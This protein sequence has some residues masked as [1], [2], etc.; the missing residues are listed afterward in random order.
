MDQKMRDDET[1]VKR[2]SSRAL[3]RAHVQRLQSLPAFEVPS[4]L[5]ASSDAFG[6]AHASRGAADR[7]M[8][9]LPRTS[10]RS[11]RFQSLAPFCKLIDREL[12]AVNDRLLGHEYL[13]LVDEL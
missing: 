2:F 12:E 10:I 6:N 1:W 7:Q 8:I 4:A 13:F 3:D 5:N 11:Q 9:R